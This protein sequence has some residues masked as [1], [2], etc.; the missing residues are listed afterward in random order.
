MILIPFS[1]GLDS[2]VLVYQALEK[3]EKFKICYITVKNNYSKSP[4]EM[5]QRKKLRELFEKKYNTWISDDSV[6]ELNVPYNN[7]I[8][9]PQVPAWMC[10]LL[11]NITSEITEVRM[12]YCMNDDALSYISD[13]KKVWAAYQPFFGSKMPKLV[14]PLAKQNKRQSK[15]LLP[16]EIFQE[17]Y[18][19]E[20]PLSYR[21]DSNK[22]LT[23]AHSLTKTRSK[24]AKKQLLEAFELQEQKTELVTWEDCG[25][26]GSCKRAI[27]DETFYAYNRNN[28]EA[29][30]AQEMKA[31]D[32]YK[33][34]EVSAP[35]AIE[36]SG[37][38]LVKESEI[39]ENEYS[40]KS[41]EG[42]SV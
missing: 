7:V 10:G 38:D 39:K 25:S 13:F 17:T 15:A 40:S 12:G 26:C 2:T 32:S 6:M 36:D 20:N 31:I 27:Y 5:Q 34:Y 24:K 11:Y 37:M 30:K 23:K 42:E 18:F 19:C 1:S 35:V 21:A 16:E 28:K 3:K 9:L 22:S 29:K 4:I 8:E 41:F 14:F 33:S